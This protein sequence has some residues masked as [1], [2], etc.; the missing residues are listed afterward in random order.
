MHT[1]KQLKK[2]ILG[3]ELAIADKLTDKLF[4]VSL[5]VNVS[6]DFILQLSASFAVEPNFRFAH[7]PNVTERPLWAQSRRLNVSA[8]A[9]IEVASSRD[10]NVA[11][12]GRSAQ[13][14]RQF[15][16]TAPTL[17][18]QCCDADPSWR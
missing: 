4:V 6:M 14:S 15:R 5:S 13:N 12:L 17:A 16:T 10:T 18:Q 11:A 2:S 8:N 3:Q 9:L 1:L 7:D